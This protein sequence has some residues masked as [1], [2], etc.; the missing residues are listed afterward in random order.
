M[1]KNR[2]KTW[3]VYSRIVDLRNEDIEILKKYD[4]K[5]VKYVY[6]GQCETSR[7]KQRTNDFI[8]KICNRTRQNRNININMNIDTAIAY[9]KIIKFFIEEKNM[10]KKQAEDYLFRSD[11]CFKIKYQNIK[12]LKEAK[13]LEKSLDSFFRLATL[14]DKYLCILNNRDSQLVDRDNEM[15]EIKN[16]NILLRF[17]Y[18][19]IEFD[20]DKMLRRIENDIIIQEQQ[21]L[22]IKKPSNDLVVVEGVSEN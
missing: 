17:D 3:I 13:E 11:E 2:K 21:D 19:K 7:I 18:V 1:E 15:L 22:D 12:T 6:V 10:T 16:N 5:S 20:I 9:Q 8:Y 4:L 14:H